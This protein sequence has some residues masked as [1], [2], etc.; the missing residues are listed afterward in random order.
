[1]L[2]YLPMLTVPG[3]PG[4]VSEQVFKQTGPT[5]LKQQHCPDPTPG[6]GCGHWWSCWE[7]PANPCSL[8][9][10]LLY[11]VCKF[12]GNGLLPSQAGTWELALSHS[13]CWLPQPCLLALSSARAVGWYS[14]ATGRKSLSHSFSSIV[15]WF[16]ST[17]IMQIQP[18]VSPALQMPWL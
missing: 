3:Q 10:P 6:G 14:D 4:A 11:L 8:S 17:L 18:T 13:L 5:K 15:Q 1:M 9:G 16:W 7:V 2:P 12:W